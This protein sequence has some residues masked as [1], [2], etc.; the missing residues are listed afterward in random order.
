M[1]LLNKLMHYDSYER[2]ASVGRLLGEDFQGLI[3]DA[4]GL[5]GSLR[6]FLPKARIVA[7]NLDE[8]GDIIYDG[9][10]F[11]FKTQ[12]FDAVISLD[13]LE[14]IPESHRNH[15][16]SEC[17]RVTN[18]HV[19]IA[20]PYGSEAHVAYELRLDELFK[21]VHGHY[22]PWLHEHVV[23]G[24]PKPEAL[25]EFKEQLAASRFA[26]ELHYAGDFERQ[27]RAFEQSLILTRRFGGLAWFGN[28]YHLL[29]SLALWHKLSFSKQLYEKTNRFYLVG[30]SLQN[31]EKI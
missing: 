23:N 15:F 9:T 12:T 17:L 13:T 14:H 1:R 3:L 10:V 6:R 28:I 26:A 5:S 25:S 4:G 8:S 19:I 29:V 30:R 7:L 31:T 21:D 11:P 18:Q 2:H 27:C 24:L 20:A 22:H 16:I